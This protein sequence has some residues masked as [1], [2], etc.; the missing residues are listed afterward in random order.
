MSAS[1]SFFTE[2]SSVAENALG[3]IANFRDK[4]FV[5]AKA[6]GTNLARGKVVV[7]PTQVADHEDMSWATVPSDGDTTV[8]VTLGGTAATADYYKGGQLVVQD[9]TGE[10]RSYRVAGNLAADADSTCTVYLDEAIDT[11]GAASETNVD[12]VAHPLSGVVIS[13][14]DQADMAVGVPVVAITKNY[15][16]WLQVGGPCS[17]LFDEAVAAGVDVT[18]GT[19]VAG[20]V[21][22]ADAAGEQVLGTVYGSAGV[23]TEYQPV[24]L[25]LNDKY[26]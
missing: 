15:Y 12:L 9:G 20:A 5:Y 3:T 6:G 1:S 17:V 7:A 22:A 18:I 8:K 19:G 25:K 2:T 10:G 13:A 24:Y 26:I 16:G 21:E 23:A 4:T 11:D 14:T